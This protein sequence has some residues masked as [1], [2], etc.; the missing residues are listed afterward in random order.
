MT[1]SSPPVCAFN[2]RDPA[3]LAAS[4][5]LPSPRRM[6]TR[7]E[8]QA[9]VRMNTRRVRASQT[10]CSV[11]PTKKSTGSHQRSNRIGLPRRHWMLPRAMMM[12]TQRPWGHGLAR[13]D[14][15]LS[16]TSSPTRLR[17]GT[18]LGLGLWIL[19]VLSLARHPTLAVVRRS[20]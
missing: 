16:P 10:V 13:L 2:S 5:T 17:P 18:L 9:A 14:S 12:I 7:R 6:A 20:A 19:A 1:T 4:G 8:T 15:C 3:V 11:A